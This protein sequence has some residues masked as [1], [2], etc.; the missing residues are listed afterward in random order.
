M[1]ISN[2]KKNIRLLQK[3]KSSF[4]EGEYK[5]AKVRLFPYKPTNLHVNPFR[6]SSFI[7]K[8]DFELYANSFGWLIR[9]TFYPLRNLVFIDFIYNLWLYL[10]LIKVKVQFKNSVQTSWI[11]LTIL[12][13]QTMLRTSTLQQYLLKS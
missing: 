6:F 2:K 9:N 8:V 1:N 4:V 5:T 13:K 12:G 3:N 10:Q 11:N 7:E